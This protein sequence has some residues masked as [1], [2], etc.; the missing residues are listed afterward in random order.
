MARL[1]APARLI[2]AAAISVLAGGCAASHVTLPQATS[3]AD[4]RTIVHVLNRT[5]Y[6]PRPGDIA[7]VA[8][9]GLDR[10]LDQQLHPEAI[11][12]RAIEE[13]LAALSA[14]RLTPA[15]FASTYYLPMIAAR[16]E[17]SQT[18]APK[19]GAPRPPILGSHLLPI[20]LM[21]LPGG[22][23]PVAVVRQN[24][25]PPDELLYQ[26]TNQQVL[27]DLQAQK[28]LRAVLSERQL[29]EVLTDFWYNHFNVDARKVEDFP[30]VVAYEREV[31]RPRVLGRFREL[32]GATAKSPAM[33]FYLDNW[34]SAGPPPP[35][36][37]AR[38]RTPIAPRSV[39]GRGLNENYAREL[40]EL[41]TLGVDGG[42]TQRDVIEVARAFTG[43]TMRKPHEATG[44]EFNEKMH[45]KGEKRVLGR[46]IR[47]GRGIEDGEEV[48]DILA[49]HPSTARFIAAKLVRHF[50]ADAGP[51]SLIER[52][53]AQFQKT[54]GDL[55]A[56]MITILTS[57][58]F[59]A[60]SST[61]TKAKT[62]V[63][64][65]A[66]A[67]RATGASIGNV[68][69]LVGVVSSLGE[70]L[71]LCQPP[72]GYSD[73]ASAWINAGA[74]IGRLN[75]AQALATNGLNAA[76][77]SVGRSEGDPER[78]ASAVLGDD[79]SEP[80]RRAVVNAATPAPLRTGLLL[81]S[82]EFQRR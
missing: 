74:L 61:Q 69:P 62:P 76:K 26:R 9:L 41:H 8:A 51:E 23:K 71:Y 66:S 14:I 55:R 28:L 46:R 36:P 32:L 70:P 49:R 29:Q 1:T 5:G 22:S 40:L 43:W 72:T 19:A 78:L 34:L 24:S 35:P 53:A 27:D 18:A 33:L 57:P 6:G 16:Q 30:V 65:V 73:R 48:L 10:Y 54:D 60:P 37:N 25:V 63:E 80:T 82:P 58:E 59:F 31:I 56:V 15:E 2:C 81:G 52:A 50:V 44:F 64:F 68:R 42:Y 67:L 79:L 7:R 21:T 77:L 75:F 47:A 45:D 13:Q 20:A 39:P 12:D 4:A 3:P 11:A 38:G 17:Y